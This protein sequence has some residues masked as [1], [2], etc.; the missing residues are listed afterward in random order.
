MRVEPALPA[1]VRPLLAAF[2]VAFSRPTYQ[3]FL[4]LLVGAVLARGR[5]T[6]TACLRA[7]GPLA[8]GDDAS[9]YHRLFSA[10]R[11]S[12]WPLAHVL[13]AAVLEPVPAGAQ[14]VV[15]VDDT[16][17]MH[18][19]RRVY[20]KGRHHDACRS[21]HSHTV[22]V[23]GHR[24]VVLAVNVKLPFAARPWALPVLAAPYRPERLNRS[25]GRR[26]KTAPELARRLV[27]A[28]LHWFPQRRFVLLG[29]GGYAGHALARFCHR[30]R[31]R[32]LTL[33]SR[34]HPRANLYD[35]PPARRPGTKGRPRVKG[36][37]RA[38]PADVV[39]RTPARDRLAA[40]VAWYGGGDREVE[41]VAGTG[42]W[43]KSGGGLVPIRWAFVRDR[44]GTHRDEY[45]YCTD[46][47]LTAAAVVS[48]YAGRWSVEV[49]F[50]GAKQHLGLTTTR[51]WAERSVTRAFPCLLGLYSVVTLAFAADVATTGETPAAADPW[52]AK[53][54]PT[55]ADALARVRRLFWTETVLE[56]HGCGGA[57]AKL[58]AEFRESLLY[59]LTR[60]A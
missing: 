10:A 17:A 22:W 50:Q 2:P 32:R 6:V 39:A 45:F 46:P 52:Y 30:H 37:R 54:E 21:T 5:H 41:L 19:G 8:A 38:A 56:R 3:R 9:G 24:W 28:L 55:F 53:A 23:W 13:A 15:T 60:A 48:L 51:Q 20:G 40:T 29:D 16:T 27:A 58:P 31:R 33:A 57:F 36:R 49:A 42:H 25:E 47:A 18:K 4:T 1:A 34:L 44:T 12:L 7:A 59:E 11:W 14:V 26:H 35:P 43:Y